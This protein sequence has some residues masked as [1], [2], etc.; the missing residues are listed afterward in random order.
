MAK[1]DI[2]S[3]YTKLG[4]SNNQIQ[5]KLRLFFINSVIWSKLKVVLS[6]DAIASE[7]P[8]GN[9]ILKTVH[10]E[11]IVNLKAAMKIVFELEWRS[12]KLYLHVEIERGAVVQLCTIYI[13]YFH[14]KMHKTWSL[15]H[16]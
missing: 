3:C 14:S 13:P 10:S 4:F 2:F 16:I 15:F 5:V 12:N 7:K 6:F 1:L 9:L 8:F 11:N